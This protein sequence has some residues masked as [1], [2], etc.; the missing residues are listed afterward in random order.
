MEAPFDG[1]LIG[2][3]SKLSN[4]LSMFTRPFPHFAMLVLSM[5]TTGIVFNFSKQKDPLQALE[6]DNRISGG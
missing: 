3:N 6:W 5:G 4:T 1:L 2:Y